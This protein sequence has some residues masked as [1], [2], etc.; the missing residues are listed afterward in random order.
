M[1]VTLLSVGEA[2]QRYQVRPARLQTLIRDGRIRTVHLEGQDLIPDEDV[3]MVVGQTQSANG[4]G[5]WITMEQAAAQYRIDETVLTR[6]V[7]ARIIATKTTEDDRLLLDPNDVNEVAGRL[8]RSR[9]GALEGKKISLSKAAATYSLSGASLSRWAK[10]GHI[11]VLSQDGYRL[12]LDES[13]VAY[14]AE[15]ARMVR[16]KPGRGAFAP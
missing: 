13:D 4:N 2:A 9:W 15:L 11:H 10:A 16:T 1:P 3:A 6:L 8:D 12:Y 7:N 14:A 5:H